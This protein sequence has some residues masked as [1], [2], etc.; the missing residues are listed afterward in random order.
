[1]GVA[2]P[3]GR[4]TAGGFA[5]M[6]SQTVLSKI[7]GVGT[8]VALARWFLGQGDFGVLGLALTFVAF[9]NL[10]QHV[11]LRDVL[12]QRHRRFSIWANAAFWMSL[13]LGCA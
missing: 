10:F 7:I 2:P 5:W 4:Q 9:A 8:Q 1:M 12:I 13:L 11:G 3:L 6:S